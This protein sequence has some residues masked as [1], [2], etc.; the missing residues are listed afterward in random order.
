MSVFLDTAENF[1]PYECNGP[2]SCIHCDRLYRKSLMTG[3]MLHDPATCELCD[4][5]YDGRP[6]EHRKAAA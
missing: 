3:E 4:P 6:N 2:G 5:E 1:Y